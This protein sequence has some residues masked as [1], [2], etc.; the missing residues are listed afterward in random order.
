MSMTPQ[1]FVSD[2]IPRWEGGMSKDPNDAGNWSEGKKGVG[3]LLGS[4]HGITGR[5]LAAY[6]K[7]PLSSL[8]MSDIQNLTLDEA[9]KIA[10]KL[11]Y[12]DVGLDKLE[13]NKVTASVMDFGWTA[14]PQRAIK[15][16]Q[17]VL[18][19]NMDGA[20]SANGETAKAFSRQM[21]AKG[22]EFMAG[23]WWAT[24]EEYYETLVANRPSDGMYLKGWDNRS[25]YFTP[26]HKEGW[27]KRFG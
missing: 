4:N 23:A 9:V 12:A 22:T 17:D 24:R 20:I 21:A 18:D 15:L 13:W 1:Q 27:W 10:L 25:D 5:T 8:K 7:V 14:G 6:R 26:N 19:C 3:T 16:L 2:Y 11:F